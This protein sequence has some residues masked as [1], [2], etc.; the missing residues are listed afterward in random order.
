MVRKRLTD[1]MLLEELKKG[2]KVSEI[3]DKYGYVE[4]STHLYERVRDLGVEFRRKLSFNRCDSYGRLVYVSRDE[5]ER[6]GFEDCSY[7][8]VLIDG[9]VRFVNG[10]SLS[11]SFMNGGS[12]LIGSIR[13]SFVERSDF[14]AGSDLWYEVE[15]GDGFFDVL[16]FDSRVK[17]T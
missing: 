17:E 10:G 4:S 13:K 7:R 16:F 5:F 11:L 8:R 1:E 2:L 6:S 9:G 3:R 12:Q 14:D 15:V